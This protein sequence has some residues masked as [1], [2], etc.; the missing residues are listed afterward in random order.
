M[1]RTAVLQP[2]KML[3]NARTSD[4]VEPHYGADTCVESPLWAVSGASEVDCSA[5]RH[6]RF[7]PNA[8]FVILRCAR[9][10]R[11]N[12]CKRSLNASALR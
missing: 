1:Y 10:Q 9:T 4:S 5:P 12:R 3:R 11:R 6:G 7:E 8:V 2:V